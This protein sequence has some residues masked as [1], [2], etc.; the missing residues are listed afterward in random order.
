[1]LELLV[2]LLGDGPDQVEVDPHRQVV[3]RL[4]DDDVELAQLHFC[5]VFGGVLAGVLLRSLLAVLGGGGIPL[6]FLRPGF[7]VRRAGNE[8]V[9]EGALHQD[10]GTNENG[11]QNWLEHVVS[12]R[13]DSVARRSC[14]PSAALP[15]KYRS[16]RGWRTALQPAMP[17][18]DVWSRPGSGFDF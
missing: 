18:E 4:V 10:D 2:L 12:R 1:L 9:R 15:Q 16:S 7:Q 6:F 8:Q 3:R 5:L 17:E 13:G 11:N 14:Q